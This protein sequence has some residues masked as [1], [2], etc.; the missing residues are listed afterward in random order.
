[1]TR[2]LALLL[3]AGCTGSTPPPVASGPSET[4]A[5]CQRAL[6]SLVIYRNDGGTSCEDAKRQVAIQE[7]ACPLLFTCPPVAR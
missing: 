5:A 1:M 4:D 2:P 3:L 6:V 7:P